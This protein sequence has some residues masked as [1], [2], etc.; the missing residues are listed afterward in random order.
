MY[1]AS[2]AIHLRRTTRRTNTATAPSTGAPTITIIS[3]RVPSDH[4]SKGLLLRLL[5]YPVSQAITADG[6]DTVDSVGIRHAIRPSLLAWITPNCDQHS[7]GLLLI[8]RKYGWRIPSPTLT[9][10]AYLPL[11]QA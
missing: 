2:I 11:V 8:K 9:L 7:L 10:W 1:W 5:E 6:R 4:L 3:R